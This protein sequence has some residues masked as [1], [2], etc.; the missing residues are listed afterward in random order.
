MNFGGGGRGVVE[1]LAK[2][3]IGAE[4]KRGAAPGLL[5]LRL[6]NIGDGLEIFAELVIFGV[7]D[8]THHEELGI[9]FVAEFLAAESA[10][11]GILA[12]EDLLREL[13]VDDG[14]SGSGEI[15]VRIEIAAG[16]ESRSEE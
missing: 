14:H 11:D 7:A 6:G 9:G 4:D 16:D 1:E 10:A 3:G 12:L 15:V 8:Q 2:R 5:V 13:L